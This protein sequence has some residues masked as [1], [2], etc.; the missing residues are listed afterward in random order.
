MCSTDRPPPPLCRHPRPPI[1]SHHSHNH[2]QW[3]TRRPTPLQQQLQPRP[4]RSLRLRPLL[5]N[6]LLNPPLNPLLNLLP[7]PSLNPLLLLKPPLPLSLLRLPKRLQPLPQKKLLPLNQ[8]PK[9]LVSC[10][11]FFPS[12]PLPSRVL[13]FTLGSIDSE[14]EEEDDDAVV[15]RRPLGRPPVQIRARIVGENRVLFL[16]CV[17][18]ELPLFSS[19][20]LLL[21]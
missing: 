11:S 5:Q 10:C 13:A 3:Q 12:N 19:P 7:N 8:L 1:R 18:F 20:H 16:Q 17:T 2:R 14:E 21:V 15:W 4:K 6:L 9:L